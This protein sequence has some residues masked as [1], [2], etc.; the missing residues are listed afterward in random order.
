MKSQQVKKSTS[1][2]VRTPSLFVAIDA[3]VDLLTFGLVDL[4]RSGGVA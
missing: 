2:Q 1:Q 3:V 4:S